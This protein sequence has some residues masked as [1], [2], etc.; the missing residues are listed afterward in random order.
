M[1]HAVL[2]FLSLGA[3]AGSVKWASCNPMACGADCREADK[4]FDCEASVPISRGGTATVQAQLDVQG[5]YAGTYD[6]SVVGGDVLSA[7]VTPSTATVQSGVPL[8]VTVTLA[9]SSVAEADES[10]LVTLKAAKTDDARR[11]AT[12]S[13]AA[14]AL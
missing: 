13:I 10:Y 11:S 2:L 7:T 9:A 8:V 5:S 3:C 1:R 4:P 6:I 12:T 14:T